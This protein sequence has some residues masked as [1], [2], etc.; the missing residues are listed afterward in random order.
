RDPAH[1]IT[2]RSGRT[3]VHVHFSD[4]HFALICGG[5]FVHHRRQHLARSTPGCPE[6]D[7]YRLVALQNF[8]VKISICYF[9]NSH[10]L[11]ES[12]C[13]DYF[14]FGPEN[15]LKEPTILANGL[16]DSA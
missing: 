4:L 1:A 8:L 16:D 7:H 11:H 14:F 6:V 2:L 10:A 5:H 12:P 15:W 9:K 3:A 13:L